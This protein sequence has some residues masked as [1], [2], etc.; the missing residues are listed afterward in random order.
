MRK[1]YKSSDL[2]KI[3]QKLSNYDQIFVYVKRKDRY[4]RADSV[5]E[6]ERARH[7]IFMTDHL[8]TIDATSYSPG[9][10]SRFPSYGSP[11][12]PQMSA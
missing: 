7:P 12:L 9:S 6:Q 8:A 1:A 4:Q 5:E 2:F 11:P 10:A 3:T